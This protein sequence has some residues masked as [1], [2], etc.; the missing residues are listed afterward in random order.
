[1]VAVILCTKTYIH[2]L[3]KFG[4]KIDTDVVT[5]INTETGLRIEKNCDTNINKE[6][7]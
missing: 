4:V 5:N 6:N 3:A 2:I 1:M 7:I